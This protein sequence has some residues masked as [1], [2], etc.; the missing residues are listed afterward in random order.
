MSHENR[1]QLDIAARRIKRMSWF[2]NGWTLRPTGPDSGGSE[3]VGLQLSKKHWFNEDGM[4]IHFETWITEKEARTKMLPFELHIMH[5]SQFPGTD[6]SAAEFTRRWH[7]LDGPKRT[8][9]NWAD[10]K[11]GRAKPLK[12]KVSFSPGAIPDVVATEFDRF[13]VIGADIDR[14]L[15]ARLREP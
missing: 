12:G 3:W 4:G 15:N 8:I 10:Y 9:S 2:E 7:T 5:R 11:F 13:H 6:K 1:K 14:V